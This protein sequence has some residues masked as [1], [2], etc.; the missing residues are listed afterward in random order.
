M[1]NAL[2]GRN[3]TTSLITTFDYP[4]LGP[5]QMWEKF[6]V[7]VGAEGGELRMRTRAVSLRHDG[8]GRVTEVDTESEGDGPATLPVEQVIDTMPL[9][10]LM[11]RLD[12]PPPAEVLE[13][14]ELLR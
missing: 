7:R 1:W 12:P 4:R 13:S 5:G 14:A 8:R 9:A 11:C 6:A 2:S 3:D 10:A